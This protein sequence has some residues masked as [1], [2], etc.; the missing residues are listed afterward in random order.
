M[1]AH[2]SI[3]AISLALMLGSCSVVNK[4]T[5]LVSKDSNTALVDPTVKAPGKTKGKDKDAEAAKP[6]PAQLNTKP[7][8]E[9]L[10]GGQWTVVSVGEVT[11]PA[12]D[13]MPYAHFDAEGRFYASDGCNIINGD[14]VIKSN[15]E[16]V[17]SNP[18]S[19]MKYC[20]D[21]NYSALIG[22]IYSGQTPLN[23]D[24]RKIGQETY[25]YLKNA[26]GNVVMTL[27][28]H[29][30]EFLNGNWQVTAID[31]KK[32][33]EDDV[34]LFVDIAELKVHG[35]TGCNFFNGSLYIDPSKSNAIDFSNIAC[36]RM[37]CPKMQQEQK[38]LLALEETATAI[39]GKNRETVLLTD[40]QG[41]ELLTLKRI[42]VESSQE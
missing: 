37:A 41:R 20:P 5:G 8:K 28:R 38:F 15:G 35:N 11:I 12:D 14:Y 21:N 3:L 39:A 17:F 36:T 19:T 27:R 22:S 34:T 40:S 29:N 24:C 13:D 6:A 42:A 30:M 23:V 9:Q 2:I 1:K 18:L 25:L 31:G 4:V 26:K 32:I 16:I 10:L 7:T 33:E